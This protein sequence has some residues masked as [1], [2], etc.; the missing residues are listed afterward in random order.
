MTVTSSIEK[1]AR[2]IAAWW[3]GL[4]FCEED[5]AEFYG[6]S[7]V[8]LEYVVPKKSTPDE[9][10][11]FAKMLKNKIVEEFQ[12]NGRVILNTDYGADRILG[13]CMEA[14][15]YDYRAYYFP[16]KAITILENNGTIHYSVNR[17][18]RW[19]WEKIKP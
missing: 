2:Y 1:Q 11:Q 5:Y 15:D 4:L 17:T 10:K 18:S 12:H 9:K 14:V 8:N 16:E 7:P 6:R 19:N 13:E 3:M